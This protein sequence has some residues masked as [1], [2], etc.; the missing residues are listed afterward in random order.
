[1]LID[2]GPDPHPLSTIG[3]PTMITG[4]SGRAFRFQSGG[5]S[6]DGL[7]T[8]YTEMDEENEGIKIKCMARTTSTQPMED[9]AILVTHGAFWE[10][11][12]LV[13]GDEVVGVRW[14]IYYEGW[15]SQTM[16]I[17][18]DFDD[19]QWHSFE[20]SYNPD[21]DK[22]ILTADD[23]TI[24]DTWLSGSIGAAGS[25]SAFYIGTVLG[26][27]NSGNE[28]VN[29]DIDEVEVYQLDPTVIP[30]T[31]F[32]TV[33]VSHGVVTTVTPAPGPY[34]YVKCKWVE[35][36]A[37]DFVDCPDTYVFSH[38]EGDVA[39]P[40]VPR[41]MVLMDGDKTVTAVF[42]VS[43]ECGDQCH[44]KPSQDLTDDCK[45]NF[46]DVWMVADKWLQCTAPECD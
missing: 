22:M 35:L 15:M 29:A 10:L 31:H 42:N 41:T 18:G 3:D 8:D 46:A 32:L 37:E 24:T 2:S 38:W 44:P 21:D 28:G 6:H 20:A 5:G 43:S 12:Y 9:Y 36:I 4:Y 17:S 26:N 45:V 19:G 30:E 27:P 7:R 16:N 33:G 11:K 34:E 40:S 14:E 13:S 1:M 39:T 25:S 23:V